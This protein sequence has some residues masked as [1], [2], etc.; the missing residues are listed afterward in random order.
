MPDGGD[1][2]PFQAEGLQGGGLRLA[3]GLVRVVPPSLELALAFL[4]LGQLLQLPQGLDTLLIIGIIFVLMLIL[5]TVLK[6]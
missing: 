3:V 2:H 5:Y 6:R 1:G 4:V